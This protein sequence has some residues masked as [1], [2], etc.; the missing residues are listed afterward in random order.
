MPTIAKTKV[1][2]PTALKDMNGKTHGRLTVLRREGH[3]HG[4][5][6]WLC[7]CSCGA[8]KVVAGKHLRDGIVVSCGCF[9][10]EARLASSIKHGQARKRH[11]TQ[12][13]AIWL[14]MMYR[15][16]NPNALNFRDYGGRGI[17][18]CMNMATFVGFRAIMGDRPVFLS[19]E[20]L[21][22]DLG[23]VCGECEEC[24]QNNWPRNVKWATKMEQANNKRSNRMIEFSGKVMSMAMWSKEI[25]VSYHTLQ[26]RL[27]SGWSVDR[28]LTVPAR[29]TSSYTT[30]TAPM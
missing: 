22:N 6:A 10:R 9:G 17:R 24:L 13:Y 21:N 20:R 4:R 14:A 28:A 12:T 23:Y 25:G 7:K 27:G 8:I 5:A 19:I 26:R 30:P 2:N 29:K 11:R 3:L 15:C 18:P 16:R 1:S